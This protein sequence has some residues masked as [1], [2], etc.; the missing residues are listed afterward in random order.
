[1]AWI[2][3]PLYAAALATG[4]AFAIV[5][6]GDVYVWFEPSSIVALG[7]GAFWA[8][9]LAALVAALVGSAGR[10]RFVLLFPATVLYTLFA[11]YGIPPLFSLSGWRDLFFRTGS[12]VYE[13]FAVMYAEPVPYDLHPGL[14]VVLIPVV[15]IVVAFATSATL[16]EKSPVIS[17][18]VLGLTIGVLSTSSFEDGAGPFFGVFLVCAVAV[19]LYPRPGLAGTLAG[20]AVVALV[21]LAPRMPFSDATISPG[22]IDWTRIGTG[23]TSRLDVQADVGDYLTAGREAELMRVESSEPLLWRGGT[24]DYFDGARWIDTT[25]PEFDDGE[26][27]APG[28]E[29]RIVRQRFEI[30]N[31]RTD[32][33]F[34]GYR[35]VTTSD[36]FATENSDGSWSLDEPLEE[37]SSYTVISEIPQPTAAQLRSAGTAYPPE[38]A[39]NFLQLSESPPIVAE[40]AEQIQREYNPATP[41]DT[42][43]AIE[44]Y[45]VHDGNFTYNLDVSYRRADKAIEEF[46]GDGREGFCTQF[47]TSMA[48]LLRESGIPSRVVY[49]ATVG[50]EAGANEYVVTGSNMHTWVEAYFPGV[51]WYP[52][53]PTPGFSMP[54]AMEANAPRPPIPTAAQ[55]DLGADAVLNERQQGEQATQERQ[56]QQE[57]PRQANPAGPGRQEGSIP[58]PLLAL[59]PVLLLAAVPL[60]KRA[61]LARGRPEDLYR[62]LT[63][64]L[65]DV[66]PPGAGAIADSP[67][68]TPTERVLLLAAAAGVEEEPMKRFARAY[69]DHLYAAPRE[70]GSG[71]VARA[72]RSAMRSYEGLPRWRR[73]FGAVNPASLIARTRR[74]ASAWKAR[75]AK[76]HLMGAVRSPHRLARRR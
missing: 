20:T 69:S 55:Q 75:L 54:S 41:Y 19:L 65:R 3:A 59:G 48:L 7:G 23:G 49:G 15:M 2:R 68:L 14:F 70:G 63:G 16:Y 4:G 62:D 13:A 51:G 44:R 61:L 42:A 33:L 72:Y 6:T 21:L 45:L 47:A 17:V 57:T 38:V 71:H 40:T 76:A 56:N 37:N 24:L 9:L 30:L 10:Y 58:W 52:F 26:E 11:A 31:A 50:R 36:A 8:M 74:G 67:A 43:R 1:M 34:G 5:F 53:D 46:L 29:T 12:D 28:I 73:V 39:Q 18:G 27:I 66:L 35:I 32:V 22:L 25:E 60:A 64:R